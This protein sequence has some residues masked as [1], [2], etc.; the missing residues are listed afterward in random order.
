MKSNSREAVV[1]L[2]DDDRYELRGVEDFDSFYR[3]EFPR[4]VDLA[5]AL[6][7][8]RLAAEDLVQDAMMVAH[9]DWDRVGRLDRP[10]AWVRRVVVNRA[11]SHYQRRKAEFRALARLAPLRG[12]PPARLEAEAREFWQQVRGLPKRQAQALALHYLD[13]LS[14]AEIAVVLECAAG[15]V[16]VHLHRGRKALAAALSIE[17]EL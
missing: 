9:A 7:G 4:M 15:T 11:A 1:Q 6:S 13:E 17:E 16:K 14:V 10:G 5:Y 2:V 12:T 8:S 3:R